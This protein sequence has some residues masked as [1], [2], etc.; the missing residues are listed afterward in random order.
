MENL[1]S[2]FTCMQNTT[3]IIQASVTRV[4][5]WNEGIIVFGLVIYAGIDQAAWQASAIIVGDL[6]D[7]KVLQKNFVDVQKILNGVADTVWCVLFFY[8]YI[9]DYI[10]LYLGRSWL[11][12]LLSWQRGWRFHLLLHSLCQRWDWG[13]EKNRWHGH[14]PC[15]KW[16]DRR[17]RCYATQPSSLAMKR[18]I[19]KLF[20]RRRPSF[21]ETWWCPVSKTTMRCWYIYFKYHFTRFTG[22]SHSDGPQHE[23]CELPLGWVWPEG[24]FPQNSFL[25]LV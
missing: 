1:I 16:Q 3:D 25:R 20:L 6:Y 15:I 17:K 9:I 24:H 21:S 18:S 10:S 4:S 19:P 23:W 8:I 22:P 14:L 7:C 12:R 13:F 5:H 2:A 11:W